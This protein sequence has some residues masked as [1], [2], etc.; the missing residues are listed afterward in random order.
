MGIVSN[1][2]QNTNNVQKPM[3]LSGLM[4][5]FKTNFLERSVEIVPGL[6]FNQYETLKRVYYYQHNQ[7]Q[8]G[9]Y[10]DLGNPKYFFDLMTGR[11]DQATK[12]I[13]IDTKDC[14][15]QAKNGGS[16]VLSW[17]LR[18]EF[19]VFAAE[20]GFGKK[21]NELAEDL[22][23]FGTVVWKRYMESKGKVNVAEVDLINI[24]CDPQAINLKDGLMMER[25]LLKQDE[26]RA[27]KTWKQSEVEKLIDSGRTTMPTRFMTRDANRVQSSFNQI[28]TTTPFYEIYEFWGEM[29]RYLYEMYKNNSDELEGDNYP[30]VLS[31]ADQGKEGKNDMVYVMA[32]VAGIENGQKEYILYLNE[33]DPETFPYKEVHFRR[34]KG[35]WLGV[36]NYELCFDQIEKANE[37]TNRFFSSLR[38]SLIHI[39]Q[40]RDALH[41]K[42]VMDDLLDGDIVVSKSS[43]DPI[44]TEIRGLSDYKDEIERIE[45]KCDQLCNSYEVVTGADLPAGTPF[46]LGQ[47]QLNSATKLFLFVRQNMGLFIEDVFNCWLLPNFVKLL[48]TEHILELIDVD[49]IG[50]YY[51]ARKRTL[52]YETI[53]KFVLKTG[54]LPTP[55]QLNV[56]GQVAQDQLAKMP[57]QVLVEKG[58]YDDI[59]EVLESKL[60]VV[61]TGENDDKKANVETLTTTF[62]SISANPAVLQ[63][64]RAMKIL[65]MIL[66]ETGFSPLELNIINQTPTNPTMVNQGGSPAT[67][68]GAP[69][70]P[71]APAAG[72]PP[73]SSINS[74]PAGPGSA[75]VTPPTPVPAAGT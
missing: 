61:V 51:E 41:V 45:K 67:N 30:Y 73:G 46:S 42:N 60:K 16:Y 7:F 36:S 39:Y 54:D 63:D 5:Q 75:G 69:G 24:V 48:T 18:Q 53:K 65:G 74:Q 35:R 70:A 59:E 31:L 14:Y 19:M 56:I 72:G 3:S 20:T 34:R 38:L 10:D 9:P 33:A 6:L 43:I 57:K 12:N 15:I 58:T 23:D 22:P 13:D 44:A 55:D 32:Q 2:Y 21:L 17:L 52:Q 66:E 37:V 47:Q 50:V 27:M 49:D 29:P 25:H 68:A 8:S 26:M 71:G 62:Q 11:N 64:P 40:T 1:V 4:R 28:D